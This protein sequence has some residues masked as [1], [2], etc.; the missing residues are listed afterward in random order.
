MLHLYPGGPSDKKWPI[1]SGAVCRV[2][3]GREPD[4]PSSTYGHG[5]N[6]REKW[7]LPPEDPE[8]IRLLLAGGQ[9]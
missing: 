5:W 4:Y 7:L 6:I 9:E 2:A 8:A 3:W 1:K